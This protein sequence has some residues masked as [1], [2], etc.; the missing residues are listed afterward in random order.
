MVDSCDPVLREEETKE[1][2]ALPS[3]WPEGDPVGEWLGL[4][5]DAAG[6]VCVKVKCTMVTCQSSFENVFHKHQRPYW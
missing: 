5:E 6:D 2:P 4:V 1:V 3:P